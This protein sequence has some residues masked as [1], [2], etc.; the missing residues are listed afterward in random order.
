MSTI[1]KPS[2][3]YRRESENSESK[4]NNNHISIN[5]GHTEKWWQRKLH[6]RKPSLF[7]SGIY[8][9]LPGNQN[10][11]EREEETDIFQP[12]VHCTS[13]C[14]GE[15]WARSKVKNVERPIKLCLSNNIERKKKLPFQKAGVTVAWSN[16][17]VEE[18]LLFLIKLFLVRI[19]QK[20]LSMNE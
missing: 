2:K 13:V 11:R 5:I 8:L 14:N 17:L 3:E 7:V 10:Y 9:F 20:H 16:C 4:S 1:K 18:M 6:V 15:T 12:Q 19:K